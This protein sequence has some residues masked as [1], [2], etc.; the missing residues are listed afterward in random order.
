MKQSQ[1]SFTKWLSKYITRTLFMAR[2]GALNSRYLLRTPLVPLYVVQPWQ[3]PD[4]SPFPIL[5]SPQYSDNLF[6]QEWCQCHILCNI[7]VD[8]TQHNMWWR[9]M[10]PYERHIIIIWHVF[11]WTLQYL[12]IFLS[13]FAIAAITLAMIYHE[14]PAQ[15]KMTEQSIQCIPLC[16][17]LIFI[18]YL[19]I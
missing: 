11:C 9:Q 1:S 6:A 12:Y 18:I 15:E 3:C 10:R 13:P 19:F 8:P 5:L 7:T 16:N 2:M 4:K 14:V 17:D